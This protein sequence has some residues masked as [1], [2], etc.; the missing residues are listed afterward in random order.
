MK[1]HFFLI[2]F[3]RKKTN[4]Q[5]WKER[6]LTMTFEWMKSSMHEKNFPFQTAFGQTV[7]ITQIKLTK[8]MPFHFG[9]ALMVHDF[10]DITNL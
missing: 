6:R 9:I 2:T 7:A 5:H 10:F 8:K 1:W 3:Q 4:T